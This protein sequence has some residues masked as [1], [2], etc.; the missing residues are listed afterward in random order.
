MDAD[1][2]GTW[3][4]AL[5]PVSVY[6][7]RFICISGYRWFSELGGQGGLRDVSLRAAGRGLRRAQAASPTA[8]GRGAEAVRAVENE[9]VTPGV[10]AP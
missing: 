8:A 5:C 2:G 9:A 6:G 4:R 10:L 1:R 3:A 7:P